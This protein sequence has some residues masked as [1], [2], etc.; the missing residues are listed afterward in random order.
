MDEQLAEFAA[1]PMTVEDRAKWD[2]EDCGRLVRI[3]REERGLTRAQL[4]ELAGVPHLDVVQFEAGAMLRVEPL[5]TTLT[6]AL[7]HSS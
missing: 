3:M 5:S 6:R 4:A 7:G 2:A 1:P